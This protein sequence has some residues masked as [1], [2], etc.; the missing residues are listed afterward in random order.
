MRRASLKWGM[1]QFKRE[2]M[3]KANARAEAKV[4]AACGAGEARLGDGT[5]VTFK[6]LQRLERVGVVVLRRSVSPEG[7]CEVWFR[8]ADTASEAP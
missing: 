3:E 7:Y 8:K 5:G 1:S 2:Q 6:T 4:L